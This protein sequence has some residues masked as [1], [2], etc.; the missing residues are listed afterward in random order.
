MAEKNSLY[1]HKV[2]N[3][4][5]NFHYIPHLPFSTRAFKALM[6]NNIIILE[7]LTEK[8]EDELLRL[9]QIAK[10]VLEEIKV[11]MNQYNLHLSDKK[12]EENV[13]Q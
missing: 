4:P 9:R 5:K 7:K 12:E 13:L 10:A 3:I 11:V 6:S 2:K 8:T 1:L